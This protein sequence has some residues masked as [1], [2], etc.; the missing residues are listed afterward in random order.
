MSSTM[1]TSSKVTNSDG[2][3]PDYD[4]F[5]DKYGID[6]LSD[7]DP[8]NRFIYIANIIQSS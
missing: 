7:L 1:L 5:P 4:A 6:L 2:F 3:E 8:M